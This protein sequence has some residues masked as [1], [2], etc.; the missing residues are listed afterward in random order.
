MWYNSLKGDNS[1]EKLN[2]KD[3]INKARAIVV[4]FIGLTYNPIGRYSMYV[5]ISIA[6]V[7]L[8]KEEEK[9]NTQD[10]IHTHQY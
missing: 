4:L 6:V 9:W 8:F 1:M 7:L 2:Y 10:L 3:L 5:S